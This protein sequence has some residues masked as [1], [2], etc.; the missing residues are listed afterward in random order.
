M[1][2]SHYNNM[3]HN[4]WMPV[5]QHFRLQETLLMNHSAA[6]CRQ[7]ASLALI[8]HELRSR[9]KNAMLV[10]RDIIRLYLNNAQVYSFS[11]TYEPT[12]FLQSA[13]GKL[14]DEDEWSL[15]WLVMD[16]MHMPPGEQRTHNCS[17][18]SAEA[19]LS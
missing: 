14:E 12:A 1:F 10:R 9:D 15:P 16:Q 19:T 18:L 3:A 17:G 8:M 2:H 13:A 4:A 6:L 5:F 7:S 11:S